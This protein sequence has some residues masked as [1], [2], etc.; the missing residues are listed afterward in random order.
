MATKSATVTVKNTGHYAIC[1]DGQAILPGKTA[2]VVRNDS[3]QAFIDVGHLE[4]VTK[5]AEKPAE[6]SDKK[7]ED[8]KG[9]AA[10]NPAEGKGEGKGEGKEETP[11]DPG[12]KPE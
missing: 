2:Q 4:I 5:K 11:P 1:I 6:K 7:P 12:A 10:G 8:S 3:V 9:S